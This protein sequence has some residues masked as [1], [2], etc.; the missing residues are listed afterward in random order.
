MY[1]NVLTVQYSSAAC[2]TTKGSCTR[3]TRYRVNAVVN[4]F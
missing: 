3:V 2:L 1:T 4:I